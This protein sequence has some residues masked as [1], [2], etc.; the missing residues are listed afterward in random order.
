MDPVLMKQPLIP[1]CTCWFAESLWQMFLLGCP[2]KDR[3]SAVFPR[4]FGFSSLTSLISAV[5]WLK[6]AMLKGATIV[7]SRCCEEPAES[8]L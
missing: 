3:R 7:K 2:P 1:S 8:S 4:C 5:E 6:S